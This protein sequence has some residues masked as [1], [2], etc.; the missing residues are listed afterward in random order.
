MKRQLD[1]TLDLVGRSRGL[2]NGGRETPRDT[3][4]RIQSIQERITMIRQLVEQNERLRAMEKA[5]QRQPN[6]VQEVSESR[7]RNLEVE[8]PQPPSQ[9]LTNKEMIPVAPPVDTVPFEQSKPIDSLELA[10]SLFHSGNYQQALKNYEDYM[11]NSAP[12]ALDDYWAVF[13]LASSHRATGNLSTA[14]ARYRDLVGKSDSQDPSEIPID[15]AMWMLGHL[16]KRKQLEDR[17]RELN[18]VADKLIKPSSR[19]K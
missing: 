1:Q 3:N 15:H 4:E 7:M 8:V 10:N 2:I 18:E 13:M 19:S 16:S 14:E 5:Q 11:E 17:F 9:Q 12:Q 6:P